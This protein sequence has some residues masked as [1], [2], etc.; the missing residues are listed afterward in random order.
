MIEISQCP[1]FIDLVDQFL[2]NCNIDSRCLFILNAISQ[3]TKKNVTNINCHL[4]SL[5]IEFDIF[6]RPPLEL[7]NRFNYSH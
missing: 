1:Q 6:E 5:H 2:L 4:D 3:I 7:T